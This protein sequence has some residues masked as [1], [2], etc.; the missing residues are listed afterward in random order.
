MCEASC[1]ASCA[2]FI[3]LCKDYVLLV[4]TPKGNW[5]FPKGKRNKNESYELCAFRE[6]EEETGLNKNQIK[7][8]DMPKLFFTEITKKGMPAVRLFVATT[9]DLIEVKATDIDELAEVKWIKIEDAYTLL[10]IKNR[11]DILKNLNLSIH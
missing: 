2:G 9:E 10:T 5:G 1:E 8:I 3:V 4:K 7:P 6:L 11:A